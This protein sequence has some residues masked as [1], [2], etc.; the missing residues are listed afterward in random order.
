ML[1]LVG[2]HAVGRVEGRLAPGGDPLALLFE[3][4]EP[5]VLPQRRRAPR[6]PQDREVMLAREGTSAAGRV[7]DLSETGMRFRSAE[8]YRPDETVQVDL[9]LVRGPGRLVRVQDAGE[10]ALEF[11]DWPRGRSRAAAGPARPL[12]PP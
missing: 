7:V 2:G 12:G 6:Y 9:E 11:V 8:A 5:D 1:E 10:Y 3:P 4:S